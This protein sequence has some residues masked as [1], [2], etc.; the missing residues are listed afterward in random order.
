GV[1]TCSCSSRVP[2]TGRAGRVRYGDAALLLVYISTQ[3]LARAAGEMN[4]VR[5]MGHV[6]GVR[7]RRR[8]VLNSYLVV[9]NPMSSNGLSVADRAR[10]Q[11]TPVRVPDSG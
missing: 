10:G 9:H 1:Q 3:L 2:I 11:R 7:A 6:R 8:A 4:R 5:R